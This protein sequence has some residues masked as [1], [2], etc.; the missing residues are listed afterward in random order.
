MKHTRLWRRNHDPEESIYNT[1]IAMN[2]SPKESKETDPELTV[3]SAI[4]PSSETKAKIA[5]E[6]GQGLSDAL[7]QAV[8]E[9]EDGRAPDVA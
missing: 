6:L 4:E 7:E 8:E 9:H 3:H 5:A 1:I 2:D